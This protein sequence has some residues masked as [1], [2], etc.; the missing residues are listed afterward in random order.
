[1]K[2]GTDILIVEDSI[3]DI[4]I[5]AEVLSGLGSLSF[6]MTGAEA[7]AKLQNGQFDVI[8]LDVM[9]PDMTGF[10]VCQKIAGVFPPGES[11]IIFVTALHDAQSEEHGLLLGAMDYILK[12]FS[13]PAVRARVRNHLALSRTTRELRRANEKL[14]QLA[15]L[16]YLTGTFNRGHF[17]MLVTRELERAERS[18]Q[19]GALLIIDLDHFKRINDTH[20]HAAGDQ[21]LVAVTDAWSRELRACDVLGRIGGEEFAVFLPETGRAEAAA[22]AGRLLQ[23]TRDVIIHGEGN[24]IL[25]VTASIGGTWPEDGPT[26]LKAMMKTA[27]RLLYQAKQAGRDRVEVHGESKERNQC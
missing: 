8:L 21:V 25:R 18:G 13:P 12:P 5:L 4:Q 27:D 20:G 24:Q 1:M 16:D 3:T 9:L 26:D 11:S 15:A 2:H 22:I 14:Q 7:L 23:R 10:D 17:E 6:V 19:P